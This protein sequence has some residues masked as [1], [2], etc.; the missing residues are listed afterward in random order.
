MWWG[1][2]CGECV[3]RGERVCEK[4]MT[5]DASCGHAAASYLFIYFMLYVYVRAQNLIVIA[6]LIWVLRIFI[7]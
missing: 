4:G 2:G 7:F 6:M 1:F 3:C 5:R